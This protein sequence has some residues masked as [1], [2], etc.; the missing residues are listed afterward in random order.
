LPAL[1]CWILLVVVLF[2]LGDPVRLEYESPV[3]GMLAVVC[4]PLLL[5]LT[6]APL[7]PKDVLTPDLL[8]LN[9]T[10][11]PNF[12]D[13]RNRNGIFTRLSGARVFTNDTPYYKTG[14]R[15]KRLYLKKLLINYSGLSN[16]STAI[17]SANKT[18][19]KKT[20]ILPI[21]RRTC[22]ILFIVRVILNKSVA[23]SFRLSPIPNLLFLP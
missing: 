9:L 7:R 1:P 20:V 21:S 14:Y 10:P 5:K 18:S 15:S 6:D 19:N 8:R 2:C 12:I 17:V 13:L 22:F 3:P 11:F 23:F 16:P 4:T